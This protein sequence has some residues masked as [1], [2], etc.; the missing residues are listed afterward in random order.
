M[1][2]WDWLE[3]LDKKCNEKLEPYGDRYGYTTFNFAWNSVFHAIVLMFGFFTV[4][5][6]NSL[7]SAN[8]FVNEEFP[9]A[10]LYGAVM[11]AFVTFSLRIIM[12]IFGIY[13][14]WLKFRFSFK[15]F[16]LIYWSTGIAVTTLL[17]KYVFD[18]IG[19]WVAM[20]V[21]SI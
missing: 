20:A 3:N 13:E 14:E 6:S 18:P 10:F 12:P 1:R 8:A 11:I 7:N 4:I 17:L 5:S 16:F 21:F 9:R 15:N 2:F 19:Y